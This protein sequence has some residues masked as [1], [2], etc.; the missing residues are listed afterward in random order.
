MGMD[1]DDK[2]VPIRVRQPQRSIDENAWGML[3]QLLGTWGVT[4]VVTTIATMMTDL[5]DVP[6]FPGL[7][8]TDEDRTRIAAALMSITAEL[9]FI[10]DKTAA[11]GR[12][13]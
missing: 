4:E 2:V 3:E 7:L 13:K 10:E 11:A 1:G 9:Y 5:P 12:T 8:V 6:A